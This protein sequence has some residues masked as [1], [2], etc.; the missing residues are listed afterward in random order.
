MKLYQNTYQPNVQLRTAKRPAYQFGVGII[1][2]AHSY[3][4]VADKDYNHYNDMP[5][6]IT[7]I[8]NYYWDHGYNKRYGRHI[9]FVDTGIITNQLKD[10]TLKVTKPLKMTDFYYDGVSK[11][12]LKKIRQT[13][14]KGPITV[15]GYLKVTKEYLRP[16]Y[17]RTFIDIA[18]VINDTYI[19]T[20]VND[21]IDLI[22]QHA[23]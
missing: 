16:S 17:R 22:N 18:W 12:D 20:D 6:M 13:F 8:E 15:K 19:I 23:L 7:R 2:K 9:R 1:E 5:K 4:H 3:A 11:K 10:F 21:F 14:K